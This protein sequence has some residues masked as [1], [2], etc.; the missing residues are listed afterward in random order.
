VTDRTTNLIL[1]AA[2]DQTSA[3]AGVRAL[4][5]LQTNADEVRTSFEQMF[6]GQS[7]VA[8]VTRQIND[9]ADAVRK[10]GEEYEKATEAADEFAQAQDRARD[11]RG[12]FLPSGGSDTGAG[13][14]T[15]GG[16]S[17]GSTGS[18]DIS[19]RGLTALSML[20]RQSGAGGVAEVLRTI[21]E[22]ERATTVFSGLG[23]VVGAA[24]EGL[25]GLSA[26]F[27]PLA[28]AVGGGVAILEAITISQA[29]YNEQ[30]K[31]GQDL[32]DSAL[33]GQKTY[34]DL[35]GSGATTAQAQAKA[36][37]LTRKGD[38]Q[39]QRGQND[40][41][42]IL[43][44]LTNGSIG[45]IPNFIRDRILQEGGPGPKQNLTA[46][47]NEQF[48]QNIP[49]LK[50]LIADM[51]DAQKQSDDY[52]NSVTRI[53]DG[54]KAGVF[55]AND[56]ADAEKKLQEARDKGADAAIEQAARD[57]KLKDT[58]TSKGVQSLIDEDVTRQAE[59]QK[60]LATN[61]DLSAD[62][63]AKLKDQLKAAAAD[64]KDL[65]ESILPA[66]E[67]REA[68]DKAVKD[69][70][71]ALD[72]FNRSMNDLGKITADITR[73]EADRA[74]QVAQEQADDVRNAQRAVTEK[75]YQTRIDAAKR[76]EA[77]QAERDKVAQ[78][79]A[80]ATTKFNDDKAKI[81]ANFFDSQ[82]KS[83]QNYIDAE[84]TATDRA[85]LQRLQTLEKAQLDLKQ[86]A[87]AGDVAGFVSRSE[88][89]KLDL[90]NQSENETLADQQR[91]EQFDKQTQAAAE[92]HQKQ[93]DDL[94]ASFAR[95]KDAREQAE[96]QRI[97]D[98]EN[99]GKE[100]NTKSAQLEQELNNIREQWRKDDLQRQ[101][102][103]EAQSYDERLQ[104]QKDKQREILAQTGQFFDEWTS[105]LI[106]QG[107]AALAQI[108]AQST[109]N[110]QPTETPE[111]I[112]AEQ[113]ATAYMNQLYGGD[114]QTFATGLP[115]VP[116]N[117]YMA[118]LDLGER[119]LTA[120]ENQEYMSGGGRSGGDVVNVTVNNTVGDIA[121]KSMLDDYQNTT[122]DGLKQAY[123]QA[124]GK[125]SN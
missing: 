83:Y 101:R 26:V 56:L 3:D 15:E 121:T 32:L 87:A 42:V 39:N 33:V 118:S 93:L 112:Q 53:T 119:V 52:G 49:Q 5:Q 4:Q 36:D 107:Q 68:E 47:G 50:P 89:A 85:N 8:E 38:A 113:Q 54:I 104:L 51:K 13:P 100:A 97:Q 77:E 37:D 105:D 9:N 34:Y 23:E 122:I 18:S 60:Q 29:K 114:V 78:A 21:A 110:S 19:S 63:I 7:D 64:E 31:Q 27:P 90:K 16:D 35:I 41:R 75:D 6:N 48:L 74:R 123:R 44:Q 91:R 81:D 96:A 24:V 69:G 109:Q 124:K 28:L 14:G 76:E 116:R 79:D 61:A 43:E 82:L 25:G 111:D 92:A 2:V 73:M 120:R 70:Q 58:G 55:A 65:R 86:L 62:E 125:G 67:A 115:Y 59:I 12:R 80:Q 106:K 66:V 11:S 98:I 72:E 30:L 117:N 102:D 99:S 84:K 17:G 88:Q 108:T 46:L 94:N 45:G 103:A 20:A 1:K 95:E 22:L 10:V 40:A 71:K 57:A